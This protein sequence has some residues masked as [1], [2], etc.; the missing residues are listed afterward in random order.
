MEEPDLETSGDGY[1]TRFSGEVG[2]Y[3]LDIQERSVIDLLKRVPGR[4]VLDVGG[5]HGQIAIPLRRE[6]YE[7]TVYGSSTAC[8]KNLAQRSGTDAAFRFVVGDLL[9]LP[10]RD[11]SFDTVTSFRL[12]PHVVRWTALVEELARVARHGVMVDFPTICS[13][14]VFT[15]LLFRLKKRIER[16]TR[17]Y[18]LFTTG[19]IQETFRRSGFRVLGAKGQFLLPMALH[20]W[21]GLSRLLVGAETWARESGISDRIGSPIILFAVRDDIHPPGDDQ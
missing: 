1:A 16:N 11:R 17:P 12:L 2:R 13:V 18:T 15:P 14:N 10:F 9:K 3:F 21:T 8:R 6:G 4:T 7:V 19:S 5:A 20:R